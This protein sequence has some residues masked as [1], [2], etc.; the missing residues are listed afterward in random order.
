MENASLVQPMRTI[1]EKIYFQNVQISPARYDDLLQ[2]LAPHISH[3][4]THS[5][6]LSAAERLA[7]TLRFLAS[8]ST[9][10]RIAASYEIGI[11]TVVTVHI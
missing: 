5:L 9:Q 8:G 1:E 7:M 11:S 2:Q 3:E 6:L 4:R 10:Q